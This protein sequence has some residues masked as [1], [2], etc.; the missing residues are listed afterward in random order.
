MRKKKALTLLFLV[1]ATTAF[2]AED[3]L[4]VA[5]ID[6]KSSLRKYHAPRVIEKNMSRN[7]THSDWFI[8][9]EKF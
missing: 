6:K 3:R 5:S 8:R 1:F 7:Y 2:A 4:E 9:F